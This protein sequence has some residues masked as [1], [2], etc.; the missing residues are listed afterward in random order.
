MESHLQRQ[1]IRLAK[2]FGFR[3]SK[4]VD[5]SRRGAPDLIVWFPYGR[6]LFI[7]TKFGRNGPSEHQKEYHRLLRKEG[8]NVLLARSIDTIREG[9]EL[10]SNRLLYDE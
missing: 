2:K 9:I 8:H 7:E 4:F 3:A 5:Q 10:F 6:I 1:A